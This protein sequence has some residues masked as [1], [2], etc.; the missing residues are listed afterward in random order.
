MMGEVVAIIGN[1]SGDLAA[2][3][4]ADIG[5]TMSTLGINMAKDAADLIL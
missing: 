4:Q 5:V 1:G 2:L 3:K